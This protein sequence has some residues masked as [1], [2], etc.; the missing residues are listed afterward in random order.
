MNPRIQS[1]R[2]LRARSRRLGLFVL[3]LLAAV[4]V[5][6]CGGSSSSSSSGGA[7]SATLNSPQAQQLKTLLGITPAEAA[8]LK[9]ASFK[10]GAI[11]PLSGA[12]ATF[13]V[14]EGNGV[15][16]AVDEMRRYLGMNITYTALDHKSGD[17]VA[18]ASDARQ[19]GI[20]GFG[21]VMNSYY[22]VFGATLPA[23]KNYHMLSFDPGGGT[24]NSFK[25]KP[26]FWGFR[27]NTPD[28]GFFG[29]RWFKQERPTLKR[30]AQVIWDAGAAYVN[31]IQ[32]HLKER[33]AE[34]GDTFVGSVLSPIGAT[35]YSTVFS[36]LKDLKPQIIQLTV[37]GA[38][39][40]Y[41][42]KQYVTS[43]LTAQVL[44]AEWTPVAAQIAG[45][46]YKN[47]FFGA[48]YFNPA[49][50]PNPYSKYFVTDYQRL[51]GVLPNSYYE[52]NY[53]EA[54]MAFV[55]LAIRVMDKRGD[56]NSG[57]ALNAA[58]IANPTFKSLYA[59]NA[60]TVGT[61]TLDPTTHDPT[62]R[63]VGLFVAGPPQKELAQWN[64]GNAAGF[65]ILSTTP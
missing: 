45:S 19:L 5:A 30:V 47:F 17:P 23:L 7:S 26:Y 35:D 24:G 41:F 1:V 28:D 32:A 46:A 27:A 25:G 49:D 62:I 11:L 9:G 40:G 39:P 4:I 52:P 56:I 55:Q 43:G 60:T 38:D 14:D 10:I 65:K 57:Q 3:G 34:N 51:F 13:A 37:F 44:G 33:I 20:S 63:P 53:Y 31:P 29:L 42:M 12:G 50:P 22:G 54:T 64:I 6:A 48:D 21:A 58:L 18:G 15:K 59:G 2:S 36:K 61:L 16:L 8:K